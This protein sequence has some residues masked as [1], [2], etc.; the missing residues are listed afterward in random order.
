MTGRRGRLIGV[1]VG[2]LA[3][4]ALGVV[5]TLRQASST[6]RVDAQAAPAI[7]ASWGRPAVNAAGLAD[8]SGVAVTRVAVTGDGGLVDLRY[9]VVDPTK[10]N[11]LH[12]QATPPAV[13]DEK[14]GLVV[15]QLFMDHS[16]S[17]TYHAGITYYLV[18]NN[19]RD[20]VHRGSRVTVLLGN[21]Q[22]EHVVVR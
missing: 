8:R 9:R 11:S 17:G 13:I 6:A 4:V 2:V 16:H 7:A 3:T 10:A 14:T 18:F 12:D 21:A 20:W 1:A 5:L 15:H 22:L 19:P